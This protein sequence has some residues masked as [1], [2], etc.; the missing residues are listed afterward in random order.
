MNLDLIEA[1][2]TGNLEKVNNLLEAGADPNQIGRYQETPLHW[3]IDRGYLDIAELLLKAGADPNQADI[4]EETSLHYAAHYDCLEIAELLLIAG[5]DPKQAND[6]G[7]T[8][9]HY[10]VLK[11]NLEMVKLLKSY[12]NKAGSLSLLCLRSI[13]RNK[14]N[15]DNI[16][17]MILEWNF[18][19]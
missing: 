18:H 9:L 8:P 19:K 12:E 3:A 1:C 2:S 4:L 13:Y 5:A 15:T 7:E 10:A 6:D 16:P 11:D 17:S 14:I